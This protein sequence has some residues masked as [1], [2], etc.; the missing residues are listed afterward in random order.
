[1]ATKEENAQKVTDIFLSAVAEI[2]FQYDCKILGCGYDDKEQWVELDGSP[3]N[4][5]KALCAIGKIFA[6]WDTD[7]AKMVK[8]PIMVVK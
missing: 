4:S 3:E 8:I 2:A 1:M 5:K 7:K 6:E